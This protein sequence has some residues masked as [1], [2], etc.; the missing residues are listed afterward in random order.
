MSFPYSLP[1]DFPSIASTF[2]QA[3]TVTVSDDGK[4]LTLTDTSNWLNN[5]QGYL[6]TNFVRTFL[7][8]DSAGQTITTLTLPTNLDTITYAITADL[9]LNVLFSIVGVVTFTKLQKYTFDRIYINKLQT[10]LM[11][12]G[13]CDTGSEINNIN[14]SVSFYTGAVALTPTTNDTGIASDLLVANKFIDLVV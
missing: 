8:T 4:L 3:F 5:T 6:R 13:C 9:R 7:L 12:Y 1:F 11:E 2:A 14:T 10:A